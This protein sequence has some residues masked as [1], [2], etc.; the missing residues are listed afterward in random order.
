MLRYFVAVVACLAV[1]TSLISPVAAE[2]EPENLPK[3]SSV[4]VGDNQIFVLGDL[5]VYAQS[6]DDKDET[7]ELDVGAFTDVGDSQ[8]KLLSAPVVV[9]AVDVDGQ[10]VTHVDHHIEVEP[11]LADRPAYVHTFVPGVEITLAVDEAATSDFAPHDVSVYFRATSEEPWEEVASAYDRAGSGMVTGHATRLGQFAVMAP[12]AAEAAQASTGPTVVLDPDNDVAGAFWPSSGVVVGELEKS[13]DLATAV[14]ARLSSTCAA[15]VVVTRPSSLDDPVSR[16]LRAAIARNADPDVTV[17][18]A[19]NAFNGDPNDPFWGDRQSDSGGA[20]VWA[21]DGSIRFGQ[22]FLEEVEAY[23]TRPAPEGINQQSDALP[24]PDFVDP[25]IGAY[26]HLEAMFLDNAF[27]Q[28]VIESG[29]EAIVDWVAAAITN[30]LEAQGQGCGDAPPAPPERKLAELRNLGYQNFLAYG[31]DPV[32]FDSGNFLHDEYMFALTGVGDQV[33]DMSLTFNNRDD[34]DTVF[35][36]G[37]SFAYGTS[38]QLD[39]SGAAQVRMADGATFNYPSN[40]QGWDV[41]DGANTTL[42]R[43]GSQLELTF[44]ESTRIR[45]DEREFKTWVMSEMIDRQGNSMSFTW[46]DR[47]GDAIY[48]LL[49]I[50]DEAGQRVV[51]TPNE[52]GQVSEI[53]HPDGRV[54][55]MGYEGRRLVSI[56]DPRGVVRS[57]DYTGQGWLS[58]VGVSQGEEAVSLL[59]NTYDGFGRVVG[60]TDGQ[61]NTRRIAY[62]ALV[63]GGKKTTYTDARG[64]E[65]IYLFNELGQLT[66][67]VDQLGASATNTYGDPDD[68]YNITAQTDERGET[69][70]TVYDDQGRPVET[71][72]A[73]GNISTFVYNTFGD[74]VETS[75]P[76]GLGGVRTTLFDLNDQGRVTKVTFGDGSFN[77]STYDEHGDVT[78]ATDANGNTTAFEYDER[79]NIIQT[80]DAESGVVRA[81]YTLSNMLESHTDANGNTT[82]F[83][84]DQVD[85]Q[86]RMTDPAGGTS[87]YVYGLRNELLSE[88]D[89]LGRTTDYTYDANLNLIR[90]D[91]PDGTSE[92]YR[93]DGEYNVVE[94]TDRRGNTTATSYDELNRPSVF[95]DQVGAKWTT[96]FDPV[97]NAI[98]I[99]DPSGDTIRNSYDGLSRVVQETD[100]LGHSWQTTYDA[101]GNVTT[102]TAPDD[103]SVSREYDV[104]GRPLAVVDEEGHRST[105]T[106]DPVGNVVTTTDRRGFTTNTDYDRLNRPVSV[107]NPDGGSMTMTYD[108]V[109]NLISST[110]E[111]GGTVKAR[112]DE[113]NWLSTTTD[114]LGAVEQLSY[115]AVGNALQHVDAE[116]HTWLTEYDAMNR[117]VKYVSP[118]GDVEEVG[119]DGANNA[120]R[121]TMADGRINSYVYNG[122]NQLV[123]VI[124]NYVPDADDSADVN[125]RSTYEISLDGDLVRSTNPNGA[126]TTYSH[127]GL[128]RVTQKTDPL[129]RAETY[130]YNPVGDLVSHVDRNGNER[131]ISYFLDRV[132]KAIEFADDTS[133]SYTYDAD[134]FR[135]SMIDSVGTT[136]WQHD[137]RGNE[138]YTNDAN[139]NEVS[140]GYDLAGNVT[141]IT[142]PDGFESVRTFDAASR[143]ATLTDRSGA[144]HYER[145]RLG[146]RSTVTHPNKLVAAYDYD[147]E[148]NVTSIDYDK[149]GRRPRDRAAFEYT[150]T[151]DNLV[152]SRTTTHGG[153]DRQTDRYAYDGVDRLISS[154]TKASSKRRHKGPNYRQPE[155]WGRNPHRG[156]S[157]HY[158][159]DAAGNRTAMAASDDP[160]TKQFDPL[161]VSYAYDHA[162]QL[163]SETRNHNRRYHQEI[164]RSYDGNGNLTRESDQKF[165]S[166]HAVG[167]PKIE[168]FGYNLDDQLVSDSKNR[169]KRDGLGRAISWSTK[170]SA[171][172]EKSF[173]DQVYDGPYLIAQM[174]NRFSESYFRDNN[175]VLASQ[176]V[177][178]D[179]VVEALVTDRVGTVHSTGDKR[180]RVGQLEEF[181]DFGVP[182]D[183]RRLGSVFGFAGEVQDKRSGRIHFHARSYDPTTGRFLQTDPMDG[184]RVRPATQHPYLYAFAN[185]VN[186][187][188]H[189]GFFLPSPGEILD[190]VKS[191]AEKVVESTVGVAS[192]VVEKG[193]S[194]AKKVQSTVSRTVSS[195]VS[196][197]REVASDVYSGGQQVVERVVSTTRQVVN[198]TRQGVSAAYDAGK[199]A[200]EEVGTAAITVADQTVEAVNEAAET[201]GQAVAPIAK[202]T[203]EFVKDNWVEITV[204]IAAFSACVAGIAAVPFTAGAS[205]V[206]VA[207]G[208]GALAG[209][210]GGIAGNAAS[211][212]TGM[213]LLEG[214]HTDILLGGATAGLAK[215]LG[216]AIGKIGGAATRNLRPGGLGNLLRGGGRTAAQACSF[217]GAT[218]V[219]LADG[220]TKP[221]SDVEVGDWVSAQDPETGEHGPHAVT[222]VWPHEDLLVEF[223]VGDGRV[224]TTEDHPFWNATD[225]K[226]QEPQDF[227]LGDMVLTAEGA[228]LPVYGIDWAT[229]VSDDA[230]DITVAGL[231]TFYILIGEHEVL[232]HNCRISDAALRHGGQLVEGGYKFASRRA[233]R[234]A[235]SEAV[236]NL[237]SSRQVI[238]ALDYRGGPYWMKDSLKRIGVRSADGKSL[239]RDDFLGHT[240]PDGTRLPPHV[241]V[242]IPGGKSHFFY[243]N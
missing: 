156:Q 19:F 66:E 84:Y 17:T 116:G 226:W 176:S 67:T 99:A 168:E 30:E 186:Y 68:V 21:P 91:F 41:P 196:G 239:W 59:T 194:G 195:A 72:D 191:G 39:G 159:Y 178:R 232:V 223:L 43:V 113:R 147:P 151:S 205:T 35:G 134:N 119:Y 102:M 162:D 107:T 111:I 61:D 243:G 11:A 88:T 3:R 89:A 16:D 229:V 234:Q 36:K 131:N 25:D 90:I 217:A 238:R 216:P 100:A 120:V 53:T 174:G 29:F 149:T 12:A 87:N 210:I 26:V 40:G 78:S 129:G 60:Q 138:S 106:Y 103:T 125:V 104:L 63:G 169:W 190:S 240:F 157:V 64:N 145:D 7:V 45:F 172:K 148:G 96:R 177:K 189:L 2:S 71:T 175:L 231:H 38:I 130:A 155:S 154:R 110:N 57:F 158:S 118:L 152:E 233:A 81:T 219:L 163:L 1:V 221:I 150:Y 76:D 202:A 46:G 212:N 128:G 173:V 97:G 112:Y 142:Y 166:G 181:S 51:L 69:W 193:K 203:T 182:T 24:Y 44:N 75:Q 140:H 180:A 222:H 55:R 236:G 197:A 47:V 6:L 42:E 37:W 133:E 14:S 165:S 220:T 146:R 143:M 9:E 121:R 171:T 115:D 56:T 49:E 82:T 10:E 211:G 137:W 65:T 123:E 237:G 187:T 200:V 70:R 23:T 228:L 5:K 122:R 209:A 54:W 20:R 73:V 204:G 124:E 224:V 77:T 85:N 135:V 108:P 74:L 101:A 206:V 94:T 139:G 58:G 144:I 227:D 52:A 242:E 98:E 218:E 225:N 126:E 18:L 161:K 214:V 62:E 170:G 185:P 179:H 153:R 80:T 13:F 15:T 208:C 79:G 213:D 50:V 235:A 230:Y 33:I 83:V 201:V 188:D 184:I 48:E 207:V 183:G 86:V 92:A 127:D 32:S 31:A 93:L 160:T 241:N 114:E 192:G 34:R 105:F 27:D 167:H 117:P 198:T 8:M 22:R 4:E 199:A 132:I 28:P 215:G 95:T 136:T 141:K 164:S 109:G